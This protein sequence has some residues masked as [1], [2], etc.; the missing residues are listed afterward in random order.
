MP[1]LPDVFDGELGQSGTEAGRL[2]H[3]SAASTI[4]EA[5]IFRALIDNLFSGVVFRDPGRADQL[6]VTPR[7]LEIWRLPQGDGPSDG[8]FVELSGDSLTPFRELIRWI[9]ET[10]ATSKPERNRVLAID[11]G[12][13]SRGVIMLNI[14]PIAKSEAVSAGGLAVVF[15]VTERQRAVAEQRFLANASA[16]LAS[17]LDITPTLQKVAELGVT[18]LGSWCLIHLL[19]Q[20][21]ELKCVATSGPELPPH[22]ADFVFDPCYP[23]NPDATV[24]PYQVMRTGEP[25][26]VE[27]MDRDQ[28]AALMADPE[29][30]PNV[31]GLDLRSMLVVPLIARGRTLGTLSCFRTHQDAVDDPHVLPL[32]ADLASRSAY[33]IDNARLFEDARAAE[34]RFRTVFETVTDAMLVSDFSGRIIEVN[35]S[36]CGLLNQ[37][38]S[39]LLER[40]LEDFL[41]PEIPL[42]SELIDAAHQPGGLT[43]EGTLVQRRGRVVAVEINISIARLLT[44]NALQILARDITARLEMERL[45]QDFLAMV[46]HDL[47]SPLAAL[48]LNAQLLLRR[49]EYNADTAEAIVTQVDRIVTLTDELAD[50][51]R[52]ESG[53]L[54]LDLQTHDLMEVAWA[55]V[56]AIRISHAPDQVVFHQPDGPITVEVDE[57]RVAQIVQNLVDNALKHSHAEEPVEVTV[58]MVGQKAAIEVVDQGEGIANDLQERIFERF[59]RSDAEK[60]KGLGLG[61]YFARML[62]EAHGGEIQV[63]SEVAVGTTFRVTLPLSIESQ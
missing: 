11:R 15:D 36:A 26:F 17:S 13:G 23:A 29:D 38:R 5:Q 9:D 8:R 14:A 60:T 48:R 56:D 4:P 10:L 1:D 47:R 41:G 22:L 21:D 27:P 7:T 53:N 40:S 25:D 63:E 45:R 31:L 61:L 55:G 54:E 42:L 33:A 20:E 37:A 28:I 57:H 62:T 19:D 32:A 16:I 12:D 52:V 18:A 51:V 34:D 50:L 44:G 59:G 24:G 39:E 43:V 30:I 46:T 3:T 2:D 49:G 58:R 35:R 6:L